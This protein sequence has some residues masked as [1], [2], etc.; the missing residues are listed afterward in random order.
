MKTVIC[1]K[2]G[3]GKSTITALLAKKMAARG[4]SVLVI[5]TD[6]SNLGLHRQLGLEAPDDFM[7]YI[8]GKKAFVQQMMEKMPKGE[9]ITLFEDSWSIADVPDQYLSKKDGIGLIAIGKIHEFG[10]GCACP[11]GA[12]SKN[13]IDRIGANDADHIFID[14][15]AGIEH[16]GRGI[17]QGCDQILAVVEP[18]Y[19]S[20]L[21]CSQIEKMG[22]NIEKPVSFILNKVEG[23]NRET[24]SRSL[25]PSHIVGCIPRNA[26]VASVG[27]NGSEMDLDL[28]E[29]DEIA[30]YIETASGGI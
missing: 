21:L 15:E 1:G 8:G 27:L 7:A 25:D 23:D 6:E 13:L 30:D 2:G 14:T 3:S 17:E 24:L 5:D 4:K 22:R 26:G 18:S 10:E 28:Q 16:F 11:M 9:P 29:I 19:E 20:L 12:L